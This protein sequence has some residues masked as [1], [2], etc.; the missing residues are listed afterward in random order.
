MN[1]KTFC[2]NTLMSPCI[3]HQDEKN[4]VLT[5]YVWYRQVRDKTNHHAPQVIL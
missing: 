1:R 3:P 4:Q 2:L 5:T